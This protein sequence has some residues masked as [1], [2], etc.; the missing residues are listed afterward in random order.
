MA[1][2][3]KAQNHYLNQCWFIIYEVLS[4]SAVSSF[5]KICLQIILILCCP[6]ANKLMSIYIYSHLYTPPASMKLKVGY[7]GFT[8]SVRQNV[9]RSVR[10]SVDRIVSDL[11][12]SNFRRFVAFRDFCK[13]PKFEFFANFWI[14]NFH[15]V[16]TWNLI[17]INSMGNHGAAEGIL[18]MQAF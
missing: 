18:R 4:R 11:L 12:L 13:I 8:S 2:C 6:G 1:W 16:L 3:L 9:R 14:C 10:P 17:W 7:T 15:L 5:T